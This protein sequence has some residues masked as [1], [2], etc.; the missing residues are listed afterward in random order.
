[1][2]LNPVKDNPLMRFRQPVAAVLAILP[3][4]IEML[5]PIGGIRVSYPVSE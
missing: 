5:E 3:N 2:N 4:G 1:M